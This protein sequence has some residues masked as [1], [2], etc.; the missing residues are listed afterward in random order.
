MRSD[1]PLHIK[2]AD[3]I[4]FVYSRTDHYMAIAHDIITLQTSKYIFQWNSP[5][6]IDGHGIINIETSE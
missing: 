1:S 5:T 2:F 6:H 3:D 4:T